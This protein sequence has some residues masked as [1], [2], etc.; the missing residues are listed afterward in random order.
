MDYAKLVETYSRLEHT[1]SRL[2][3]TDIVAEFLADVPENDLSN[4]VLF[5]RG[6]IFPLYSSMELGIA[7]KVMVKVLSVVSGLTEDAIETKLKEKGDMGLVAEGV[8]VGKKQ[9]TLFES[10]ALT[11]GKVH[12]NLVK[13]AGLTGK[14]SQ[15][16]KIAYLQELLSASNP[17]EAKYLIR[18]VL[19]ELRLGV[20]EGIVRDAITKA[21]NVNPELVERAFYLTSD[22]GETARIAKT[23][24]DDGLSKVSLEPCRPIR[25]M[26]AQKVSGIEEAL[27]KS[28]PAC[29]EVKY[30]GARLQIHKNSDEVELYT[31][32]LENVT[33]QFPEIVEWARENLKADKT[34]VEGEIVAVESREDRHPRPFQDLSRRIK[35][36]YDIQETV[37]RIPVE[38]NLFDLVYLNGESHLATAF[39]ERRKI[40]ESIVIETEFFR[41]A[42]QLVTDDLD[43]ANDFYNKALESGHEG[44]MAK[45]PGAPYQPGSRV[46][47]M[48]KIKPV[49]ESLD[50]VL[51][52]ATWG[53][54]RRA[55]W[56]ASFLLS[57]Y[58]PGSGEYL[59]IGRMGTGL[60]DQE[61]TEITEKL[62]P[63]IT[64]EV[65]KGVKL[66]PQV[67]V[68]VAY[69]K[70]Q[71]SPT[72]TSGYALRFPRLVRIREDKGPVDADNLQRVEELIK[73]I[74]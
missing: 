65:G 31:R 23:G 33:K 46:G 36:K 55:S 4:V 71:K 25:V 1:S 74:V 11:V 12:D 35:R 16:K 70:I 27:N 9:Q 29:F 14:G 72:Y 41:L 34:I 6:M 73:K 20:G 10:E 54:G 42:K 5:L 8:F 49:M 38:V 39:S 26:L 48:Y 37:N 53:E 58:N 22:L 63:L 3:L 43:K 61:F 15:D 59:D 17:Q 67:V 24:G 62:K 56:L 47:Y 7:G 44:V 32:R 68:E 64:E 69:E 28:S 40:L 21:F 30:D 2:E 13:L 18:L 52:G 57:V 19:G 50:L 45:N 51:T 60:T 66:K